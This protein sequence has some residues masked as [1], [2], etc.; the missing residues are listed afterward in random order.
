[1]QV[2]HF[3]CGVALNLQLMACQKIIW[4]DLFWPRAQCHNTI[5]CKCNAIYWLLCIRLVHIWNCKSRNYRKTKSHERDFSHEHDKTAPKVCCKSSLSYLL[6]NPKYPVSTEKYFHIRQHWVSERLCVVTRSSP[7]CSP[8]FTTGFV[9][10]RRFLLQIHYSGRL[11]MS[12]ITFQHLL[13][14]NISVTNTP[15]VFPAIC[16]LHFKM[17]CLDA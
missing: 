1:M 14:T 10:Q 15:N 17:Q 8:K 5:W 3:V 9:L 13:Y 4:T 16:R 2:K 7:N 6:Y 12:K 11:C